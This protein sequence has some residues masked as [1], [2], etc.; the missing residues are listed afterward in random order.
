[1][2]IVFTNTLI[3]KVYPRLKQTVK[4]V[5][6]FLEQKDNKKKQTKQKATTTTTKYNNSKETQRNM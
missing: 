6:S 3:S 2:Y 1:M 5:P 4:I